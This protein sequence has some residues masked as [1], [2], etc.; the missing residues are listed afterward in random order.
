MDTHTGNAQTDLAN[1]IAFSEKYKVNKIYA[2]VNIGS[3]EAVPV[4]SDFEKYCSQDVKK[5]GSGIGLE[6]WSSGQDD[7]P[8][9][10]V[11]GALRRLTG[12]IV[13]TIHDAIAEKSFERQMKAILYKEFI[14]SEGIFFLKSYGGFRTLKP[15]RTS[16]IL[17]YYDVVSRIRSGARVHVEEGESFTEMLC[18]SVLQQEAQAREDQSRAKQA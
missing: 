2:K 10:T 15:Y 12:L 16:G 5:F 17:T 9:D 4:Q 11:I 13:K 8:K 18:A 14:D 3:P 6:Y 1:V 7:V